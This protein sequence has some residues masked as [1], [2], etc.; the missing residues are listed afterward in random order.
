MT[1]LLEPSGIGEGNGARHRRGFTLIELLVV[2]A[3][4]AILAAMLLPA[5]SNA[6]SKAQGAHCLNNLRQ[7]QLAFTMYP[8]DNDGLFVPNEPG[9]VGWVSGNMNFNAGNTDNTNTLLL[10]EPENA[11]LA[12]YTESPDIYKCVADKSTVPGLGPRVRSLSMSQAVGTLWASIGGRAPGTPVSGEW[13]NGTY[14]KAQ[15]QW[16]TYGKFAHITVPSPV[17]LFVMMDEHPDSINDAGL[18][19]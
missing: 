16:K 12:R 8:D 9:Q 6:K 17:D 5:L 3:I 7:I 14:S 4:I 15:N 1:Q 13:L 18:A 10:T 2:I 19:V 11:K